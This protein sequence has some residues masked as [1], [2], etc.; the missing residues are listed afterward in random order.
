MAPCSPGSTIFV[1]LTNSSQLL[2]NGDTLYIYIHNGGY[3]L[4][5]ACIVRAQGWGGDPLI[6]PSG[7]TGGPLL[8][9][10]DYHGTPP[11]CFSSPAACTID[12]SYTGTPATLLG[13]IP[14]YDLTPPTGYRI[15]PRLPW[16]PTIAPP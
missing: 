15:G 5:Y 14:V 1:P 9:V 4:D 16:N 12:I 11:W 8:D 10:D 7:I 6:C 13:S 2:A 3:P